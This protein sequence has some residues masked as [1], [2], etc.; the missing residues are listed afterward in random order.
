MG[1]VRHGVAGDP[2]S[3]SLSPVLCS[4]VHAHLSRI[5]GLKLPNLKGVAVIP[6]N[7]VENALAWGY[8]GDLPSPPDWDY[9]GSPLGKFRANTLLERAVNAS[10][11]ITEPDERLPNASLKVAV[12]EK[13]HAYDDEVWLSLTSPLKHQLSAAAVR[14]QDNCMEIRSVNT[15]RWDGI[16]WSAASTDGLGVAMVADA[17]GFPSNGILGIVG[18]GGTARSTAAA[19]SDLGGS[20]R[21]IGGKRLLDKDGPWKLNYGEPDLVIDFDKGEGD[22][23]PTYSP[24]EGDYDSRINHLVKV[25]DGRWLLCAQHL[26]SWA[27]LWA[28]EF[29]DKLPSLSLLMTR[30]VSVEVALA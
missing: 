6:T 8:A 30:L 27:V 11:S 25:I 13:N 18:G 23:I 10:L 21:Q 2:I 5:E 9:V 1:T 22:I 3:H 15:M 12:T 16:S 14:S 28:P 7:G 4:I 17:F 19:W 24:M 29:A 26:H 20:I